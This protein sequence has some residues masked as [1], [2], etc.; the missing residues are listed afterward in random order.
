MNEPEEKILNQRIVNGL[1]LGSDDELP[2]LLGKKRRGGSGK[3]RRVKLETIEGL[4]CLGGRTTP[5]KKRGGPLGARGKT[6]KREWAQT[7]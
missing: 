5:S 3:E 6:Y 2:G 4:A 1:S 7:G